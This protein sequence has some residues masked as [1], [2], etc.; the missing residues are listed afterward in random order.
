[1]NLRVIGVDTGE[2]KR[3]MVLGYGAETFLDF[4]EFPNPAAL[5]AAVVAA[6]AGLGPHAA[7]I[8]SGSGAAYDQA[9]LYLRAHGTLVCVGLPTDAWISADVMLTVSKALRIVGSFVGNRQ[10]AV[11][12]LDFVARGRVMP[13]VSVEPLEAVASVFE[14]MEKGQISGRVVV[15]C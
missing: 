10:D 14:K 4:L 15:K 3:K 13:R 7:L 1:M 9:L 11:E 6:S 2:D 8:A 5:T 12:A